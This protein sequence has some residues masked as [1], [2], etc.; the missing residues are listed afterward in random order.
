[1]RGEAMVTADGIEGGVV[2]ALS[3]RLRDAIARDGEAIP[4]TRPAAGSI[5]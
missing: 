3:A 5:D 2:Y 4:T 1:M